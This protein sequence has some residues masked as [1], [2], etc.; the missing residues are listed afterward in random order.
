[1][2]DAPHA[3]LRH[4]RAF[5]ALDE[6]VLRR[7][8]AVCH[9]VALG[10]GERIELGSE[11][12]A[13]LAVVLGG[14]VLPPE[15]SGL[16][17]GHEL[18]PGAVLGEARFFDASADPLAATAARD[19]T[20]LVLDHGELLHLAATLPGLWPAIAAGLAAAPPPPAATRR[21][22]PRGIAIVAAG[23]AP[24]PRAFTEMFAA[25]LDAEA[26]CQVLSSEGLGQNLPGGIA[27]DDPQVVHWLDEQAR[28]FALVVSV[29][30]DTLTPWTRTALA[31]ADEVLLVGQH[32]GRDIGAPLRLSPVEAHAIATRGLRN[33]R[34]VLYRGDGQPSA[35]RRWLELRQVASAHH[36]VAR[37]Q[38]SIRRLVRF[39]LGRAVGFVATGIGAHAA[40]NLGLV[41]A[42]RASGITLDAFGGIAAGGALA[43]LLA[44]NFDPDDA[45]ELMMQLLA[46]RRGSASAFADFR[47]FDRALDAALPAR[48]LTDLALPFCG[49]VADLSAGIVRPAT[50][51]LASY[52]RAVWP[53]SGAMPLFI[54]ESGALL[55]GGGARGHE[56]LSAPLARL[57]TAVEFVGNVGPRGFGPSPVG[58]RDLPGRLSQA[59]ARL[60]RRESAETVLPALAARL[61][62]AEAAAWPTLAPGDVVLEPPLPAG[63]DPLDIAQHLAVKESAY[64]WGIEELERR[65]AAGDAQLMAAADA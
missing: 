17:G 13:R 62:L 65:G 37:D 35:M 12:S 22:I 55:A 53:P 33:C 14:R 32:D 34:F 61:A 63:L 45:D 57:G 59:A 16:P 3:W 43:A 18:G 7:L 24:L 25:A 58:Y 20:L 27:L 46:E 56:P 51:Q 23:E 36:V 9:I 47:A 31:R 10:A 52:I 60:A 28:R 42:L 39:V 29:A 50:G 41:K 49:V 11:A 26:E 30:D 6:S 44:A 19:S 21:P 1:M 8:Y 40:A 15:P 38:A 4:A 2:S 5:A 64:R 54:S 48:D